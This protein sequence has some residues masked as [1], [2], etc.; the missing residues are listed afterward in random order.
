MDADLAARLV[1]AGVDP[2]RITDPQEAW[3]RLFDRFGSRAT[4]I[5]RYV[6][7]AEYRGIVPEDLP[8]EHRGRVAHEVSEV[9]YPGIELV[10]SG[11]GDSVRV[12]PYDESWPEL[13]VAWSDRLAGALGSTAVYIEHVGSTAVP[14]LA[15]KPVI[16]IQITV[17]DVEDEGAYLPG[18][19]SLGLPLRMRE[20]GHRYFRPPA[21][22][23][24]VVQIHVYDGGA[25]RDH[26]LFRDYLRAHPET[27]DA[28]A[29]LKRELAE[30]YRDDRLAYIA[31]KTGFIL[32]TL[33]DACLWAERTAWT[34]GES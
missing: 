16:D 30:H 15:A 18:I 1:E 7:E 26:L 32:D 3:L 2:S 17:P 11:S 14:G 24:R 13:F 27:R 9:R 20:P 12:V 21:G 5:D 22:E 34:A 4:L 10:D 28:Y 23:P 31:A 33:E 6:L 19:E 29:A 8:K 25:R